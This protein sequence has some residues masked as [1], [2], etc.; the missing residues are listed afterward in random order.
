MEYLKSLNSL[1]FWSKNWC[2]FCK[3]GDINITNFI[4]MDCSNNLEVLNREI[5]LESEQIDKSFYVLGFNRF[6]K[7]QVY[8]YKFNSKSYLYK[9]LAHIMVESIKDLNLHEHIDLICYIPSHR[10]KEAIRGYN[11]SEL[12]AK[13]ISEKLDL[14]LSKGNLIKYRHTKEQNKLDK[15]GRISNLKNSFKV[16]RP[17][18]FKGKSILLI[19]DIVTT[20]STF[21]ECAK[22][23]NVAGAR[24]IT[25]LALTSSKKY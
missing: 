7:E 4:C 2:F 24:Q 16:K 9:P 10:R 14:K 23:L 11:Q 20:G 6:I 15:T 5:L 22:V 19:D 1:L 8:D 17:E 18:E 21:I 13:Y 3:E 25:T 12:L